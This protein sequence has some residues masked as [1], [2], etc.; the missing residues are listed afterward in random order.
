MLLHCKLIDEILFSHWP[1]S[2]VACNGNLPVMWMWVTLYK[3]LKLSVP[4]YL[5]SFSLSHAMLML[6]S[7]NSEILRKY[8]CNI[9]VAILSIYILVSFHH[10][11]GL[12]KEFVQDTVPWNPCN[13]MLVISL[14]GL[15]FWES[16]T[17]FIGWLSEQ[18][19]NCLFCIG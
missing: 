6:L 7:H 14:V 3:D 9:K 13:L 8:L 16:S 1:F 11:L 19:I 17:H 5:T 2:P 4:L 18:T 12:P 15:F 10:S